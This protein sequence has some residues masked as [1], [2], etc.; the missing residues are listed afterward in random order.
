[1]ATATLTGQQPNILAGG[2][3]KRRLV[4]RLGRLGTGL[5]PADL[6]L[7]VQLGSHRNQRRLR[8]QRRPGIIQMNAPSTA[9]FL[10]TE[11]ID[12]HGGDATSPD[13][14]SSPDW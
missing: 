11:G 3:G 9:R 7:P 13:N 8:Q 4:T 12:V 5:V 14:R 10:R 1:M 2:P 6:R